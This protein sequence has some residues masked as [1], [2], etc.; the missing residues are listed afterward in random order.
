MTFVEAAVAVL[1]QHGRPL[2]Y[3]KLVE[4][5][6]R[7]QL[8][9]HAGR[10]PEET[11]QTQLALAIKRAPDRSP[12]V[13]VGNGTYGLR[14][15]PSREEVAAEK[16]E[17]KVNDKVGEKVA[18]KPAATDRGRRGGTK[19]RDAG[20]TAA[21][22]GRRRGQ[23]AA[24][25][26]PEPTDEAVAEPSVPPAVSAHGDEG[27]VDR[28]RR[29]RRRR[30]EAEPAAREEAPE[31]ASVPAASA[32]PA[33]L[34]GAG[35]GEAGTGPDLEARPEAA[36]EGEPAVVPASESAGEPLETGVAAADASAPAKELVGSVGSQVPGAPPLVMIRRGPGPSS[37]SS[38]TATAVVEPPRPGPADVVRPPAPRP[39][40][41]E[42]RGG[43]PHERERDRREPPP[44]ERD[45]REPPHAERDRREPPPGERR[46]ER[47][48]DLSPADAAFEILRAAGD[49]RPLHARQI[50]DM[51]SK[52]RL[53]RIDT[54]EPW[55]ALRAAVVADG[56]D[57]L[58]NGLRPRFRMHGGG[59]Y[60]IASR[61][62]EAEL[63]AAEQQVAERC[64]DLRRATRASVAHLVAKLGGA[65]F[66]QLVWLLLDRLGHREIA[67]LRRSERRAYLACVRTPLRLCAAVHVGNVEDGRQAVLD[68]RAE[69]QRIGA[70]A[71][72]LFSSGS[73]PESTLHEAR[74]PGPPLSLYDANQVA[75][76]CASRSLGV[77]RENIPVDYLDIEFFSDLLEG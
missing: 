16:A 76:L 31:A 75:E 33:A 18:D 29:R 48:V 10:T 17:A 13:D 77:I 3:K 70:R 40:T 4:T 47:P 46:P 53:T 52:R 63:A 26:T 66:E 44:G 42:L 24:R 38:E 39:A 37:A 54:P 72:M 51:A 59:L 8:L 50:L 43:R 56:R 30:G 34:E 41:A 1:R 35:E 55:R 67:L 58:A 60:S 69:I 21:P 23:R 36:P 62:L 45:R 12:F 71:G 9:T 64:E 7:Q 74:E 19:A 49:G 61:H 68:L 28:K 57:R 32:V 5:A 22:K 14:S 65:T 73:V 11:M 2:H 15:Y 27:R 6:L 25:R 20:G